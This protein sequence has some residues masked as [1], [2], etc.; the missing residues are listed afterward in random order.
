MRCDRIRGKSVYG[1]LV[2][3][4]VAA[5]VGLAFSCRFLSSSDAFAMARCCFSTRSGNLGS[6]VE[7]AAGCGGDFEQEQIIP[8]RMIVARS[9]IRFFFMSFFG[10]GECRAGVEST[11][12]AASPQ[13]KTRDIGCRAFFDF[14]FSNR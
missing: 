3:V 4:G 9:A 14:E 13:Q 2:G 8:A 10:V 1:V 11:T 5:S 12:A 6:G 7:L